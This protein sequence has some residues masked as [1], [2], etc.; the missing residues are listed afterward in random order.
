MTFF[1]NAPWKLPYPRR[2]RRGPVEA[3]RSGFVAVRRQ[4][5]RDVRVAAPLKPNRFS[6]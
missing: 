2:T 3:V 5:I 6:R 4:T 1:M